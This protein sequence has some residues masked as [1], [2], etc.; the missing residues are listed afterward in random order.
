LSVAGRWLAAHPGLFGS[1]RPRPGHDPGPI[2][3]RR[4]RSTNP[5]W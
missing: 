1:S 2:R 3:A 5:I 4:T